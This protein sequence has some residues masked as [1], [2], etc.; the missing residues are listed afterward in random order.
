MYAANTDV[1]SSMINR[2]EMDIVEFE[3]HMWQDCT[4]PGDTL[5]DNSYSEEVVGE[6]SVS[7]PCH[8]S[9]KAEMDSSYEGGVQCL[10]GDEIVDDA[11]EKSIKALGLGMCGITVIG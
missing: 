5:P 3:E 8:S 7:S 9:G 1:G 6:T 10:I 2:E 11:Q 4:P